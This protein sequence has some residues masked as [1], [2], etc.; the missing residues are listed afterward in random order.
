MATSPC[1]S[2]QA[3]AQDIANL[4]IASP[5][6]LILRRWHCAAHCAAYL[7]WLGV[8]T[9]MVYNYVI[10]TFS[11]PFGL[12]FLLWVAV[13]GLCIFAVIAASQQLTTA[14]SGVLHEPAGKSP[15]SPGS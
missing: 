5:A 3:L 13:L 10:Y 8:V 14:Q 7:L 9:S 2:P 12:L 11:I 6:M 15:L 4:G 1:L